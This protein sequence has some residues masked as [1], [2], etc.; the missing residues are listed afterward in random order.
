MKTLTIVIPVYNEAKRLQFAFNAVGRLDS[1]RGIK[2][3][4]VIFVNDGSKDRTRELLLNFQKNYSGK[5]HSKALI[6]VISYQ[7]NR[8]R[9]FAV[10][11]GLKNVKTDY[12]LYMDADFSIP[13]KN[14]FRFTPYMRKDFDLLIGSK[15]KPGAKAIQNRSFVRRVVGYGHSIVASLIL[16]VFCWDFQGGFKIFSRR[17]INEVVPQ[18]IME[19]WGLD[20]EVVFL[21]K[22]LGYKVVELPVL[23]KSINEGST[24]KLGRD[25]IRALKDVFVI[26]LSW[27]KRLF[28]ERIYRLNVSLGRINAE[29]V[30]QA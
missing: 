9:G 25:I 11:E 3:E 22:R 5:I 21:A 10:R 12:G 7:K 2:I 29:L 16:G 14:I 8:G 23:W 4:K 19:R 30:K 17:F 27:E 24:V 20:M 6:E 13:F 18:S 28:R 1:P 15:K 26:R